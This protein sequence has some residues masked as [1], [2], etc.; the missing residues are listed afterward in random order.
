VGH[1]GKQLPQPPDTQYSH[2]RDFTDLRNLWDPQKM[3]S[4]SYLDKIFQPAQPTP[5]ARTIT[6]AHSTYAQTYDSN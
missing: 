4:N 1:W 6:L 2:W 5:S 3:F